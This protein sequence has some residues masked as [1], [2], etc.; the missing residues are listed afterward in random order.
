M[1][2]SGYGGLVSGAFACN[3]GH[4]GARGQ[5]CGEIVPAIACWRDACEA[6]HRTDAVVSVIESA[7][8]RALDRRNV[9]RSADITRAGFSYASIGG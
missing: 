7:P 1:I 9:Y 6:D 3:F 8:Y 4:D 5:G 2:G